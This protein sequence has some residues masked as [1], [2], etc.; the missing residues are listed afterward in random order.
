VT[1]A[2]VIAAPVVAVARRARAWQGALTF[3]Y[4]RFHAPGAPLA[5]D[6]DAV[7]ADA[8]DSQL[9][10]LKR[11]FDV[12]GPEDVAAAIG[13]RR[14]RVVCV[15]IDDGYRD[16]FE[17]AYP[18]L[19]ANEVP[20]LFFVTTG[21]LDGDTDA[22]WDELRWMVERSAVDALPA[23]PGLPGP[24]SLAAEH[25][26]D[27]VALLTR[28]YA[29]LPAAD[30]ERLL[31]FVGTATGSG[32][33]GPQGAETWMT[34]SMVRELRRGGMAIGGH[35][36]RHAVLARSSPAEQRREVADCRARLEE[37]LGEPMRW[38]AYPVGQRDSFDHDSRA[39][40]REQGVEL[41]F[42]C[43]GGY[44]S[45]RRPDPYDVRRTTVGAALTPER[46]GRVSSLPQLFAR[47]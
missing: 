42:S 4:H 35:T 24:V 34:W 31:E 41:A 18:V 5:D 16:A 21:F 14:P 46:L 43:Y 22:W 47:W 13:G 15:T 17:V 33:R 11:H 37:E 26:E 12:V 20:G 45:P 2:S 6:P 19:A 44:T 10:F 28:T 9:R 39:A 29:R 38:F 7:A 40:V 32:R 1:G 23:G 3:G 25:R 8:F 30:A 36:A 27:A